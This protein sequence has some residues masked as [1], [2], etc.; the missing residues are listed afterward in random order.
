MT[1]HQCTKDRAIEAIT[2]AQI[3]SDKRD[4]LQS[5]QI[6]NMTDK[7]NSIDKKLSDF[8]KDIKTNYSTKLETSNLREKV[9]SHQSIINRIS[10]AVILWVL[11]FFS[12]MALLIY[13]TQW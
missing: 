13:K 12:S 1:T 8:I 11:S 5:N 2:K 7:L 3:E 4:V 6:L 9:D 10:W